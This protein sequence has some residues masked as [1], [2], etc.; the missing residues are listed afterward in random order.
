MNIQI[1]LFYWDVGQEIIH[2]EV[3]RGDFIPERVIREE[4]Q[5]PQDEDYPLVCMPCLSNE[6]WENIEIR[7][8]FQGV[9]F[10]Q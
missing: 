3:H 8:A 5:H 1:A 9:K 6:S 2:Q 4:M 7:F 10:P